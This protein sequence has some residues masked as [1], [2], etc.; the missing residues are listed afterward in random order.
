MTRRAAGT[1]SRATRATG[2]GP[3]PAGPAGP[4]ARAPRTLRIGLTGPIGCGKSTV[5][6]WLAEHGAVVI[7][8]DAIAREVVEPNEPALASVAAAFGSAVI[9]PDG[10]LDRAALAARVFADPAALRRLE[11]IVRPAVRPRI[12]AR[13]AEAEAAKASVVVLEA[14]G[15][16]EGGYVRDCDEVWL[17]SCTP[18]EQL[19]RLRA[20]GDDIEDAGRRIAAQR[21]RL[22]GMGAAATRIIRTSGTRAATRARVEAALAAALAAPA[23]RGGRPRRA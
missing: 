21:E 17:V 3:G 13:L 9:R 8:A 4:A 2:Q 11:A 23:A 19:A 6:A 12:E 14:I 20:R 22:P 10:S 15:L 1:G 7:D 16:V 5:A 18:A